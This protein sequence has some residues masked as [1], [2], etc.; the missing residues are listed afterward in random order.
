MTL[1]I[2]LHSHHLNT[3]DL[4][5][6]QTAIKNLLQAGTIAAH[7][8]Q[9][10]FDIDYPREPDDPRELS[11]IPEIRLWFIRLDAQYPWL[12][13]LLDWQ[14]G[15]LARYTAM[16]VPHQFSSKEGIQFNPEALEI[17]LMHKIFILH[18]WMQ[19]QSIPSRSR[20]KSMGQM[21]GYDLED[22]FFEM[23]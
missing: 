15:E 1:A 5:P 7:E 9:L 10:R 4:S 23:F 18:D 16:L 8:Q 2:A 19:Q 20:L 11:E 21:F 14:A 17:F 6:A 22:T 13:F 3:L 12:P